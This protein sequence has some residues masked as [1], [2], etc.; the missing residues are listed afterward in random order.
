MT[1]IL[2]WLLAAV[3]IAQAGFAVRALL[4]ERR[5]GLPR[6]T[7]RGAV[8][9]GIAVALIGIAVVSQ[10]QARAPAPVSA[11]PDPANHAAAER[12][13]KQVH[14]LEVELEQRRAALAEIDPAAVPATA[15][16]PPSWP[17]LA[18]IALVLAGFAVL[19]LGDL[20]T[21]L[22]RRKPAAKPD[23][24]A[25]TGDSARAEE[26]VGPADLPTLVG[27]ASAGRYLAGLACG[28]RIHAEHLHK[29]EVLDLLYLRAWCGV[30]AVTSPEGERA[31][32]HQER[33]DKLAAAS[34][35]LARLLEL[36]P[37]MAE[38]RWLAAYVRAQ[39]GQ[40]QAAL[41]EMRAARPPLD[42]VRAFDH[43]ES[44]C[45]LM[46]AETKLAAADN[47]GATALFDEVTRLGVLTG[48]IPVAMVTHRILTV[49]E[50]TR[51]GKLAEAAEGVARI[52]Q[53]TGLDDAAQHT[54][55]VAC[56][57]YDVAIRLRAGEHAEALEAAR[58]FVARWLTTAL[59][60]VEDQVADEYLLPAVD[61][62]ALPLPADLYRGMFFVEAV[63]R[64][65]LAS[66]RAQR[67]ADDD[68]EAIATALLRALQLQPR[69]RDA[70]AALAALYLAYRPERTEKALAWLDAAI[71][72]GVRSPRALALLSEA[73]RIELER[74]HLLATFRSAS[75]RFL[76]DPAVAIAVRRALVEELGRFDE[77]RP[78]LLELEAS[79]ALDA[80][81]GGE[82]TIAALR[83]RAGFVGNLAAE[84]VRRGN[85]AQ[86]HAL[87]EIHRELTALAN[88]VDTSANRIAALERATMAQVG[89][90]VLR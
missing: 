47:D 19:T 15:S 29:L 61:K 50:H 26:P 40:W 6:S 39:G 68:V 67:L 30:M 51:A 86:I 90:I 34:A 22:P 89:R 65:E 74:T 53:I 84:V 17:P 79:G 21:L 38:A 54:T 49:R 71:V 77:F 76:S 60:D 31:V 57:V 70:L 41:D 7:L 20:S 78:V 63:A 11:A 59:P 1:T 36:A 62:A 27:H 8:T 46:L 48:E 23:A 83:D 5:E 3:G 82:L 55:T 88:N 42:D 25:A 66:R 12:L 69:Q 28:H 9:V 13:A 52:R 32:G 87:S 64:I 72:M 43:D 2:L 75:A 33:S 24:A 14:D 18:A 81:P 85:P 44:V 73:R 37:H 80:A 16:E 45:L 4:V 56:D 58:G 35:D 10:L